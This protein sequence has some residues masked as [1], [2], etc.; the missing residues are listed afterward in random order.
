MFGILY[1][2]SSS[3]SLNLLHKIS[4]QNWYFP[5]ACFLGWYAKQSDEGF[6]KIRRHRE[7]HI[8]CQCFQTTWDLCSRQVFFFNDN[9]YPLSVC[10]FFVCSLTPPK[11]Q[12]PTS[13]NFERWFPLRLRNIRIRRT[14]SRKIGCILAPHST[15]AVNFIS[16][17]CDSLLLRCVACW[18][19]GG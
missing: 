14:V 3:I 1:V 12:N 18:V 15:L 8:L 19:I 9:L 6:V 5:W 7:N 2:F 11:L 10:L 13:W 16:L 4:N 17:Q